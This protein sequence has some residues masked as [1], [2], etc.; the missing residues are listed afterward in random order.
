L[1]EA[2]GGDNPT[3]GLLDGDERD[4]VGKEPADRRKPWQKP[5]SFDMGELA[6]AASHADTGMKSIPAVS[7]PAL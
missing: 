6:N 2:H 4:H 1:R 3:R 7:V 5:M